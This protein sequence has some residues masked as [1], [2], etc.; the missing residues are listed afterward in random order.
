M[1]KTVTAKNTNLEN[2]SDVIQ[3]E[4]SNTD[5]ISVFIGKGTLKTTQPF[6]ILFY[7]SLLNGLIL[8]KLTLT[9]V[10][11]L[12][13]VLDFVST[14]NVIHLTHQE[15]ADRLSILRQQVS[16]SF[17]NLLE[18]EVLVESASKSLFLNPT[19]ISK[20][21]L[22]SAKET[23]GYAIVDKNNKARKIPMPF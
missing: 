18:A 6:A 23:E 3:K 16:K 19:L 7:R 4:A 1:K 22:R 10:K 21:S 8:S 2:L 14:G 17:K 13:V 15:V 12:L 5:N 9:D 11:V 20:E